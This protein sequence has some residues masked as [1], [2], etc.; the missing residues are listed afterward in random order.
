M[1]I[2]L[3]KKEL[4]IILANMGD[5][6]TVSL[7]LGNREIRKDYRYNHRRPPE[8]EYKKLYEKSVKPSF[9]KNPKPICL[10][11]DDESE[12][13]PPSVTDDNFFSKF[14]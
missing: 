1:R 6:V 11:N 13:D 5:S 3:T 10:P 12:G 8:T 4:E 7:D 14:D 9:S 2:Q